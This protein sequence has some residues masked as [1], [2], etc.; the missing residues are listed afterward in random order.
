M[1]LDATS[2]PV[3]YVPFNGL[4]GFVGRTN[5]IERLKELLFTPDSRRIASILGLGG[6]GKSRLAL[7]LAFQQKKEHPYHS[8]FWIEASEQLTFERD[9]LEIG[10]KLRIPGIGDDKADIKN[11][12]KQRLSNSSE[13]WLLIVDNADDEVL[14]G[15]RADTTRDIP[16]LAQYLPQTANGSIVITTR[17]RNVATFV[18][19]KGVIELDRMARMEGVKMFQEILE[20][21]ELASDDTMML[22][23][24]ERLAGLPLALVQ[25][26]SFINMNKQSV[27]TYLRLLDQP[28]D[29]IIKLLSK[30][31]G[32]PS[33]Y[34]NARN[35]IAT[36]WLISFDHIR[37]NYEF[38]AQ[39]LSSMACIHETNIPPSLLPEAK[40]ELDMVEAI[41][42]LKGYSFVKCYPKSNSITCST[43]VYSLH[44]LVQLAARNWL[45]MKGSFSDWTKASLT[46]I[47]ELFPTRDHQY[48]S[49]W[50][51]YLPHAQRICDEKSVKSCAARYSLLKKM[52]L[53]FVVDGKYSEAVEAH[54]MVVQWREQ[55]GS[56]SEQLT[57]ESYN[58]LGEALNR[59]GEFNAAETYLEK[60]SSGLRAMFGADHRS[61]LASMANLASTYREQGRWMQAE[62]L[63][64]EVMEK[65]KMVLGEAHPD[66]SASISNLA[67]TYWSQG[68]WNEAERLQMQVMDKKKG[69]GGRHPDMLTSMANLAVTYRHQGRFKE[70]EDL[71]VQVMERREVVLGKEHPDTLVSM[72]NLASTY[73]SQGRWKQAEELQVQTTKT[74]RGV[75]G[76]E[77]PDTL[78]SIAD[79]VTTYWSQGRWKEAEELVSP[80][81]E[82]MERV[83]G[84]EHPHTI[85]TMANLALTYS[86]QGRWKDA[87]KLGARVMETRKVMLG[88]E[89]P[90]TLTSIANL[91]TTYWSQGRWK[92]AEELG[93]RV[94]E[95]RKS[96]LG[97]EH[98]DTL[99]SM[100][101]LA[102]TLKARQA[103]DEA[104]EL[105][106]SCFEERRKLLGSSHSE[107]KDS[108]SALIAWRD[109]GKN[110]SCDGGHDAYSIPGTWI[111]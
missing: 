36:T 38:A 105:M 5:E 8:V 21:P 57:L 87:E 71:Q 88:E 30:D 95:T 42:V 84:K 27:Q 76:K 106:A 108:Q 79:L 62:E 107:T 15:R 18:A 48:R 90:D 110:A 81:I 44:Q 92:E 1:P 26:A 6:I 52:G 68:R 22:T 7:E 85:T 10:K 60:A 89:H 4:S 50:I 39:I 19:G 24:T 66:T 54:A 102:H 40:S 20:T 97:S 13:K 101:N 91:A 2:N 63:E 11:L 100:A 73:W 49:I 47:A 25:A 82:T 58:D 93:R 83:L 55:S 32:D 28:E 56:C 104:I 67:L 69:L 51:S 23:L 37:K 43:E 94:W 78:T 41:G 53:C 111:D 59:K 33:R 98:P 80:V 35:P 17:S 103:N 29:E 70:A 77:H 99:T 96:V 74:R 64:K 14:W 45:K 109:L 3:W 46:R 65:R 12:F 86:N 31:F 34:P 61:T 9:V 72:A 16:S 75:L